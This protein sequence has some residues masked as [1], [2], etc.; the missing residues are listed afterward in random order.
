M[1]F[2]PNC[3]AQVEGKFCA[4]CGAAVGN[5]QAPAAAGMQDNV[6]GALAYLLGL[7]TGILF[8]VLEPYNRSREV[9]FHAWQSILFNVAIIA[10][11]IVVMIVGAIVTPIIPILGGILIS[12]LSLILW[13]GS[14]VLWLVLMIKT[15]GRTKIVLPVIGPVAEKQAGSV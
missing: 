1:A 2:C 11:Y 4:S 10:A 12:L 8:L 14:M 7:I 6:A 13:L 5:A 15:Y 9:R 3:G